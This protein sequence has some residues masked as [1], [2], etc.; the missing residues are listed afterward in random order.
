MPAILYAAKFDPRKHPN[1]L[2]TAFHKLQSEGVDAQLVMVGSGALEPV[3]RA[4][5][6]ELG[7]RNVSFPGFVNQADLPD[8]YSACDVFVLPSDN[9]PWGLAVNEAMC[10]G[11]PVVVSEE[12]GCAEDLVETGVNGA[13]FTAGSVD[14]LTAALR[15]LLTNP[16]YRA[17]C[18]AASLKRMGGW[19]YA[20]CGIGLRKAIEAVRARRKLKSMI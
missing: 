18:G 6:K 4:M 2:V 16:D 3:L 11:L 20:E 5:V 19:S 8:V 15:P 1:D 17:R 14:E 10:A 9:E 13:T 12:V 7:L